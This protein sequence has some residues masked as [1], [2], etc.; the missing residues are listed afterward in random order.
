MIPIFLSSLVILMLVIKHNINKSKRLTEKT[1]KAFWENESKANQTRKADIS[2]L[3][4]IKIPYSTLPINICKE[5][6]ILYI[7]N[8]LLAMKDQQILNLSGISN[9]QLKLEYGPANLP[10]L[11]SCDENYTLLVRYLY[12]W[13]DKLNQHGYIDEACTVLEYGISIGSDIT[14]HYTLLATIYHDTNQADK[15]NSLFDYAKNIN[16]LSR[17]IILNNL[18]DIKNS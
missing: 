1:T 2:Q 8:Q 7:E 17:D 13:A 18:N 9:T 5:E 11:S 16:G 10:I 15:Y 4:Y 14:A 3:D 6:D 12:Q